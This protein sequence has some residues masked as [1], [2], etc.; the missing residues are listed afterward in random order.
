MSGRLRRGSALIVAHDTDATNARMGR[1]RAL[2]GAERWR[3]E[4]ARRPA[5]ADDGGGH[6]HSPPAAGARKAVRMSSNNG[7]RTDGSHSGRPRLFL[8]ASFNGSGSSAATTATIG[9]ISMP[10]LTKRGYDERIAIGSLAGSGTLS[11]TD[12]TVDFTRRE[13]PEVR[14]LSTRVRGVRRRWKRSAS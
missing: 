6:L 7:V 14:V 12:E 4:E 8:R 10:E 9:R 13:F 11:P 3:V 5:S 2:V 1:C